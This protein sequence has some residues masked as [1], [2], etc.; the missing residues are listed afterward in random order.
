MLA[1]ILGL[2]G[3]ALLT[4]GAALIFPPLGLLVAGAVLVYLAYANTNPVGT[5]GDK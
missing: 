3:F 2:V 4:A 1:F 5:G